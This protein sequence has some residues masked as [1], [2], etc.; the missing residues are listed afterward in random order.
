MT[1]GLFDGILIHIN[2]LN[3]VATGI[4]GNYTST[5]SRG[6]RDFWQLYINKILWQQEFLATIHQQVHITEK[7]LKLAGNVFRKRFQAVE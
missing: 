1:V 7:R 6:N 3:P 5:R 4:S 2:N